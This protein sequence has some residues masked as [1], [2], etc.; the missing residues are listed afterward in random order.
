MKIELGPYRQDLLD[1]ALRAV[2]STV[3]VSSTS[4]QA[5][6]RF[7]YSNGVQIAYEE[8]VTDGRSTGI[9]SQVNS[10]VATTFHLKNGSSVLAFKISEGSWSQGFSLPGVPSTFETG[11]ASMLFGL[12]EGGAFA[13]RYLDGADTLIGNAGNNIFYAGAGNDRIDGRGGADTIDGGSGIDTA[14]YAEQSR[15]A[16]LVTRT[17]SGTAFVASKDGT[18]DRLVG[19]EN[20]EFQTGI[21]A[22]SSL[23]YLP[24]FTPVPA[25][26]VQPIYRFYNTRDKAFFYTSSPAERDLIIR[27]S[28]DV[29]YSPQEAPWPY[30]YQGTT[31]EQAHS[32]AGSVPLFRFYNY[33]TGHHFF[34]TS[35]SERDLIQRESNDPSFGVPGLWPFQY[36][37]EAFRAFADPNHRDATP[38]YR[39]YNPSQDRHFFTGSSQEATEIRLTGQWVDEGVGFWGEVP[40]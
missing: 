23:P 21:Q 12:D 2:T 11:T 22:L 35:A 30:F 14:V 36:E 28:T 17:S 9:G 34:T 25:F 24:G 33:S 7:V 31:F 6:D 32:S 27:Q 4:T 26:A 18:T 29:Q 15:D 20:L 1:E 16:Y 5:I 38:V 37:G 10:G 3:R 19:I 39:F 40:G 8:V 13:A